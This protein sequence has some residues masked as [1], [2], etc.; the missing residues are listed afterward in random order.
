[1][2][3]LHNLSTED[4]YDFKDYGKGIFIKLDNYQDPFPG[5][6]IKIKNFILCMYVGRMFSSENTGEIVT[7]HLFK[8]LNIISLDAYEE[9]N[10][11]KI[12]YISK[13]DINVS[14]IELLE[15]LSMYTE[16]SIKSIYNAMIKLK[17]YSIFVKYESTKTQ[18]AFKIIYR[19]IESI[20]NYFNL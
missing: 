8:S 11:E 4:F 5:I 19:I 3:K 2:D 7:F 17:N 1:M 18:Y 13:K 12:Q 16:V 15:Y 9:V 14:F 10:L 6:Q 20:E